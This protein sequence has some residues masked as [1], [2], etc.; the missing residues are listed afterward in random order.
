MLATPEV[1]RWWPNY[2]LARVETE[3]LGGEAD[4]TIYA[5]ESAGRLA[6][7]IQAYEEPDAE[8]RLAHMDIFIDPELHGRGIGPAA[9]RTFAAQLIDE[10]GHHRLTI[11]PAADNAVAIRVYEKVGFRPVGRMRRYQRMA[12][13]TWVDGL[14]MDLLADE[15]VR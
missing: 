10:R 7:A 12:D 4:V 9:I 1:A 2:D 14:L 3:F 11:D 15:L 8:F 6:G 5:I 13:G